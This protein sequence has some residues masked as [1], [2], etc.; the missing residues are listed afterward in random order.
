ML[1]RLFLNDFQNRK[2]ALET[3]KN[4]VKGGMIRT[5]RYTLV[6]IERFEHSKFHRNEQIKWNCQTHA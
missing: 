2:D 6:W 1:N 4:E 5:T 3:V